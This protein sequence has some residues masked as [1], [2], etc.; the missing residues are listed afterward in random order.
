MQGRA[1]SHGNS[2]RYRFAQV[3]L[4]R[5][6]IDPEVFFIVGYFLPYY[7]LNVIAKGY[8]TVRR[9]A[10]Q[11]NELYAITDLQGRPLITIKTMC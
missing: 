6:F 9:L 2:C 7:G 8:F 4:K 1:H 3:L 5:N 10:M 11:G